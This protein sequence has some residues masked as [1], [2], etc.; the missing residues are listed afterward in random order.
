MS[1]AAA[2][3]RSKSKSPGRPPIAT[4][5]V[6]SGSYHTSSSSTTTHKHKLEPSKHIEDNLSSDGSD[7]DVLHVVTNVYTI[8]IIKS[9]SAGNGPFIEQSMHDIHTSTSVDDDML[10]KHQ[11]SCLV[12][13]QSIPVVLGEPKLVGGPDVKQISSHYHQQTQQSENSMTSSTRK[14]VKQTTSTQHQQLPQADNVAKSKFQIRSIVEI[15]ESSPEQLLQQQQQ[16]QQQNQ[17][18]IA[19]YNASTQFKETITK[20]DF[21]VLPLK[22]KGYY[23]N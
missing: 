12:T 2:R 17:Q 14:I 20:E 13:S 7:E 9:N 16:Q 22:S 19:F 15:Y 3:S 23:I 10:S 1:T 4:S 11:K 21:N 6:A 5:T 8:P 18:E